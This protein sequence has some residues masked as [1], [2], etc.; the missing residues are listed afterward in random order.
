MKKLKIV[1]LVIISIIFLGILIPKVL[2]KDSYKLSQDDHDTIISNVYQQLNNPIE[3]LLIQKI[4]VDNKKGET[5]YTSSYTFWG[6]KY[7]TIETDFSGNS[8]VTWRRWFE[9]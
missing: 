4:V 5:V 1:L 7:A 8:R 2:I 6:L 9:K 3:W